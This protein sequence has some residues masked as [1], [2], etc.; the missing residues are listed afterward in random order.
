[1]AN[2]W[3]DPEGAIRTYLRGDADVQAIAGMR[4]FFGVPRKADEDTFPLVTVQRIG[5]GQDP[6]SDAPLDLALLQIDC[7]GSIDDSGNGRKAEAT[8]L[9]N[10]VRSALD[11]IRERTS[12]GTTDIFGV[13]VAGVTWLPDP[14]DD[15]PRYSVT[16][17]VIA[18]HQ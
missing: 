12:A 15:R 16:A 6:T 7:W 11:R 1:M 4:V 17:E 9:V 18:I 3:P 5:G 13:Q 2:E 8:G 10:A 14:A